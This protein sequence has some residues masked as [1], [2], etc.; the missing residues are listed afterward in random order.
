MIAIA[1]SFNREVPV[2]STA[3]LTVI[4][5]T[6]LTT[7]EG[8]V[9]AIVGPASAR[10]SWKLAPAVKRPIKVKIDTSFLTTYQPPVNG[11]SA[12]MV[13]VLLA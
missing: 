9:M 1:T 10:A 11:Q 7:P 8:V 12:K 6:P 3:A 13:T 5:V 2:E 4:E